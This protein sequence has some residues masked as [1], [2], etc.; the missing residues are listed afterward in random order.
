MLLALREILR[1]KVRFGL[2][3]GAIG[4]LVFLIL[5]QQGLLGGLVTN[6]IGAVDN[7]NSPVLVFNDQARKNVE[8]S[9]LTPE[10]ADTVADVDGVADSGLIGEGTYTVDAGDE[11]QDAVLFGY[12][13]GGLGEPLTLNDGRLP[14]GPDEGVA[15]SADADKGFAVGDTVGIVGADGGD[16][17]R[18]EIVGTGENLR[19]SVSPTVFVSYETFEAS[20][21]AVNPDA[22]VVFPSLV[23]VEPADGVDTDEL[24]DRIDTEV[25]GTEALTRQEAVDE[26]P[27]VQGVNQSFGIILLLAFLVVALVVGFFFLILTVQ[28]AKALTLLRAVGAPSRYLVRNLL[29][30]IALIL[31]AGVAVGLGL[32]IVVGA[33]GVSGDLS[34]DLDLRSAG[35]TIIGLAVI[36]LLG[37]LA[38]IRRVLKIDPL[39][40]TLDAGREI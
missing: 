22:P 1:A 12:E 7:Q 39:R 11:I 33:L 36:S 10:Q 37:G 17:P 2:L 32:V 34:I 20:Q 13:L 8:G 14:E 15:S 21:R 9:F 31:G 38:S 28:K 40:A 5:F 18:I 29:V 25:P 19:W 26:N 16:G 23:A 24:T 35:L 4:L 30:Q 3:A 27:G 6:F